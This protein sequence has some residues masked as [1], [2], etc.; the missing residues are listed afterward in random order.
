M[1]EYLGIK[2]ALGSECI[3]FYLSSRSSTLNY[4][5]DRSLHFFGKKFQ[6]MSTNLSNFFLLF[7]PSCCTVSL[8][9]H[10][11]CPQGALPLFTMQT[12]YSSHPH[13]SL[14]DQIPSFSL[15]FS[16][17]SINQVIFPPTLE[18]PVTQTGLCTHL[19]EDDTLK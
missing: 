19:L 8:S 18:S 13:S 4:T 2:N 5:I 9:L 15:A 11:E 7:P 12:G 10:L 14:L 16:L 1:L 6:V 3:H 17:K